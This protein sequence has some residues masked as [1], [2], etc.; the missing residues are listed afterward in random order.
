M[1]KLI[2]LPIIISLNLTTAFSQVDRT[3]APEPGPAPKIEIGNYSKFELPNGLKVFVVENHRLPRV[4]FAFSFIFDPVLESPDM[5][6]G[7]MTSALIGTGTKTRTKD[8]IN[9]EIDFMGASLSASPT[10]IYASSLKKHMEKLLDVVSDVAQNSVFT[11]EELE[12]KRTQFLSGLAQQ[13]DDP[14]AIAENVSSALIYGKNHPYGEFETESSVKAIT[15]DMCNKYYQSYFRPNIAYLSIVG[16]ITPAEAKKVAEKYF[17]KWQK[18]EVKPQSYPTPQPPQATKVDIV[19]RPQS[20]QSVIRIGYPIEMNVG[21]PD[22]IKASV[23]NTVLGGGVFRLFLNLREK[24]AYTYGAYSR[25][26][27]NP[28]IGSFEASASVRN[29]VTDS[30]VYQMLYEMKRLRKEPVPATELSMVKNYLTGNFALS[31]ENPQTIASFAINTERYKLPK[32]FYTNYLKN[33]EVVSPTDVQA[34]AQKYILPDRS[35]ILVVGKASVIADKLKK[36]SADGKVEYYD[37]DA[38]PYDPAKKITAVPSNITAQSVLKKYI[39]AVGGEANIAKIKT[40]T[41]K[42]NIKVQGMS[43]NLNM[44]YKIPG[45]FMMEMLMNG[46]TLQKQVLNGDKGKSSGMQG[47]KDITGDELEKLKMDAELFP[48]AKYEQSNYK[49]ELKGIEKIDGKDAYVIDIT[50]PTNVLTTEYYSV[51]TG[52]KLRSISYMETPNGKM[53]QT[54][55]ILEYATVNGIQFPKKMKTVMGPQTLDIS[56]D[57]MEANTDISDEIFN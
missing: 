4:S 39:D 8:Q 10:G 19:D 50:S 44:S 53:P 3:K 16:D 43:L 27:S 1:K 51:E 14:N 7:N 57:T 12:K 40:F 55:D 24:H 23:T 56:V 36:F 6:I 2:Y 52:L 18:G 48:E 21:N 49:T 46:Q 54:T 20:V 37:N 47:E 11:Q 9:E 32:D 30:S 31:L 28:L 25:I 41:L 15:L 42:G 13:K 22:Y 38:N 29:A 17:G 5:G 33:I 26:S 45:K 35:I 34:M